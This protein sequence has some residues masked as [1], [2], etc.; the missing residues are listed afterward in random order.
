[1]SNFD[2]MIADIAK[3]NEFS[4]IETLKPNKVITQI[5]KKGTTILNIS[6]ILLLYE[7]YIYRLFIQ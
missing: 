2:S 1:M 4:N 6:A 3:L 7:L 5:P